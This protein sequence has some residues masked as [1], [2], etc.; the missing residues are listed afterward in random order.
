ME[1]RERPL[2]LISQRTHL[3]WTVP[4]KSNAMKLL[5]DK[6]TLIRLAKIEKFDNTCLGKEG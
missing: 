1:N 5:S 4:N 6:L 2:Q 3:C